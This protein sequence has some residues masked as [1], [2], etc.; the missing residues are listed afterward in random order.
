MK[1]KND[2]EFYSYI[3]KEFLND[4]RN[5]EKDLVYEISDFGEKNIS[6][7][8]L[9]RFLKTK[10]E[11]QDI[12]DFLQL[13]KYLDNCKNGFVK[14]VDFSFLII[15]STNV[16]V[17]KDFEIDI[18][19]KSFICFDKLMKYSEDEDFN[20]F[21]ILRRSVKWLNEEDE[22]NFAGFL[23]QNYK[24]KGS[25]NLTYNEFLEYGNI[26]EDLEKYVWILEK[27]KNTIEILQSIRKNIH[28]KRNFDN[29]LLVVFNEL[30]NSD[31]KILKNVYELDFNDSVKT[32]EFLDFILFYDWRD[33]IAMKERLNKLGG[34][35]RN[36]LKNKL[37]KKASSLKEDNFDLIDLATNKL[38]SSISHKGHEF[39]KKTTK[40][41]FNGK[42]DNQMNFE[43]FDLLLKKLS[44]KINGDESLQLFKSLDTNGNHRVSKDEFLLF[45]EGNLKVFMK[46]DCFKKTNF[47]KLEG[48]SDIRKIFAMKLS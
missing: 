24:I 5:I 18:F 22:R 38:I 36:A 17:E 31:K 44:S 41:F 2:H 21:K 46:T 7:I 26:K 15:L 35:F 6:M 48:L 27:N 19:R 8:T 1:L 29:P 37:I 40:S 16:G 32:R 3:K 25:F 4:E 28:K 14:F 42:N 12:T 10:F 30:E 20:L 45:L 34:N 9:K 39:V 13:L 33:I 23:N 47:A 43:K 11:N